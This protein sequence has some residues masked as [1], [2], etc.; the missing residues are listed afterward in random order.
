MIPNRSRIRENAGRLRET[1]IL[2]KA[3]TVAMLWNR[4]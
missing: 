4:A 1:R 3:A 2:A